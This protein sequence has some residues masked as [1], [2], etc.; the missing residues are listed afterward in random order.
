MKLP[1]TI[2]LSEKQIQFIVERGG[3][4]SIFTSSTVIG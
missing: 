3:V 4:M 2:D 1:Q